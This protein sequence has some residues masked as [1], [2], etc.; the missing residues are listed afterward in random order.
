MATFSVGELETKAAANPDYSN[1]NQLMRRSASTHHRSSTSDRVGAGWRMLRVL[2]VDD[3]HD[4]ADALVGQVHHLGHTARV[5]FN[6]MAALRVA[7]AQNPDVLL[8]DL[9]MPFMDGCQVAKHLR[10]DFPSKE[11]FIIAITERANDRR[12]QQCIEGGIDLV[13]TKPVDP[14]L[15]ETLLLLECERVNRRRAR[16]ARNKF[17]RL[18]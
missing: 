13:L 7:A 17:N 12:R 16:G 18:T 4:L 5:A 2:V 9:E 14:L 10:V 6:G 8:L 3:E 15:V 11:C 1:S